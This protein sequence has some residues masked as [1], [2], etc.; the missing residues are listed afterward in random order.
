M[1]GAAGSRG[2][3][4]GGRY[5]E[6]PVPEGSEGTH[7][8][9]ND[10]TGGTLRAQYALCGQVLEPWTCALLKDSDVGHTLPVSHD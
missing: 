3:D 1:G 7:V 10:D 9:G 8:D 6:V 2:G 5:A 4:T